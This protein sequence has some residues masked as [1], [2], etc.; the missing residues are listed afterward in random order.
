MKSTIFKVVTLC[1]SEIAR[2]FKGIS[3]P[4]SGSKSKAS[5]KPAEAGGKLNSACRLLLLVSCLAYSS[6]LKMAVV[7]SS[8]TQ[9][10]TEMLAFCTTLTWLN[11]RE[12]FCQN[13]FP[14][15]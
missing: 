11:A 13:L 15:T 10:V 8:K 14:V 3:P 5:K 2:H 4:S 1:T 12:Y 6:A 7:C 9:L